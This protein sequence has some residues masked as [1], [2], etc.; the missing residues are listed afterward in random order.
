M[1]FSRGEEDM[2]EKQIKALKDSGVGVVV[3]GGKFGDLALHYMNKYEMMA[4]RLQ[5]KFD[6][7]RV[8]QAVN[9]TAL[10]K[11]VRLISIQKSNF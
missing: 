3:S 4:V 10:P 7:R 2:L 6:V 5:S 8:S 9:A 11:L 1:N